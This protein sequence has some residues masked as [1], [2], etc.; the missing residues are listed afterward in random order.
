MSRERALLLGGVACIPILWNW[1]RLED[2]SSAGRAAVLVLLALAPAAVLNERLR[3]AAAGAALVIAGGTAFHVPLGLHYPGR[4]AARF[5]NGFL[6]FYDVKLPFVPAQ[7]PHMDGA[8]LIAVFIFSAVAVLAVCERRPALAGT[9]VLIGAGWPATLL[10]G[11][12]LLRGAGILA[13]LLVLFAGLRK[14]PDVSGRAVLVGGAIVL[15][16]VGAATS[17]ALAKGEFLHWQTWDLHV[18]HVKPVSVSYVWSSDYSGLNFPHKTT[19][20]LRIKAPKRPQYWRVT[21]LPYVVDG[22]WIDQPSFERSGD[23]GLVPAAARDRSTWVEQQVTVEALR[24]NRPPA[25]E[26][27]M[28]FD[29]SGLGPANFDSAGVAYL[30]HALHSGATYKA[31]SYEPEPTPQELAR[32]RPVYPPAITLGRRYL[33]LDPNQVAPTF[34]TPARGVVLGKRFARDGRL[35]T[36]KPLYETA[37]SVAGGA[38]SPYAAAVALDSWFRTGGGFTYNQHPPRTR[39]KP[40]LVDFVTHTRAGYCQ[41]FAGAMALMLR[42]LGVPARAAAG[43]SSGTFQNGQWTVTDHDAHEWVEVWFR[44]WGWVPFDPTPSRGGVAGAY[45]ASSRAFDPVAAA[46]VLAGKEGL[47]AFANRRGEIGLPE[48][49]SAFSADIRSSVS[50]PLH[51]P[52][53]HRSRAPG[54]LKLAAFLLIGIAAAI[55]G[56]KLAVRRTRYLTRDPRRLAGACRRELRDILLDQRVHVSSSATLVELTDLARAELGVEAGGLGLHGTV[57]RFAPPVYAR[58]AAAELRRSLRAGRRSLRQEL[59]RFDRVRGLFS[60]RSLG[61]S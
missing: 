7:H 37:R 28:A 10:R 19:V 58:E 61:L 13:A 48:R 36:Y 20:V 39:G 33:E 2:P 35:R 25:A 59:T 41:H 52:T 17:P 54:L 1:M 45:S 22:Q 60:L 43:F 42:Y 32:S 18:P 30:E 3:F 8:I 56:G 34:G 23:A 26:G 53:D 31:W 51:S 38:R 16:A 29:R 5:W 4:V 55:A 11:S 57:A 15:A 49:R 14:R 12:D 6:E 24:D 40:V 46:L 50:P 27:P 21:T 47:S 44:G 9:A